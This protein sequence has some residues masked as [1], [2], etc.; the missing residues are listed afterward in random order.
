MRVALDIDIRQLDVFV[1]HTHVCALVFCFATDI[2][3]IDLLESGG[4]L[5]LVALADQSQVDLEPSHQIWSLW[6]DWAM[7]Q[8]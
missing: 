5:V 6:R 7:N 3:S 8:R 1:L 2:L 4:D